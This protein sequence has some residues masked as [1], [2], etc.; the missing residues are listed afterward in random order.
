MQQAEPLQVVTV[1]GP[2]DPADLGVTLSHDHVLVDGWDIFKSY[3]VILDDEETAIAELVRYRVAG[4]N[5]ICDPTNGG[6]KREPGGA[7]PDQRGERRPHRDGR[8]LVSRARLS[9]G[10][11]DDSDQRPRRPAGPELTIGVGGHRR[12]GPGSSAR[13]APSAASSPRPRSA[14]SAPRRAPAAGRAAR[15]S[16]T[17]RIRA[18]SRSSR[19]RCS[20]RR[21]SLPSA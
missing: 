9:A 8:G 18:S 11:R 7:A 12:S 19:S 1:R 15:S 20:P 5:A 10:D 13:S 21:A 16:P 3:A 2:I 4:G 17:P 14:C 6:L